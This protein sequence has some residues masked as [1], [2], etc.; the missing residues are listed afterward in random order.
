MSRYEFV[1]WT[2]AKHPAITVDPKWTPRARRN[3]AFLLNMK[4]RKV[5][6]KY[7]HNGG[8]R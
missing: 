6:T 8:K 1:D 3:L 2:P 5:G 7:I 4:L